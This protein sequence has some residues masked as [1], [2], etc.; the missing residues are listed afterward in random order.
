MVSRQ[1]GR[2]LNCRNTFWH[3]LYLLS[4]VLSGVNSNNQ[5]S[6]AYI[7]EECHTHT[8][9]GDLTKLCSDR[10]GL[11]RKNNTLEMIITLINN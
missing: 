7:S 11:Q 4:I 3:N 10:G 2:P 1:S 9:Y 8:N 5:T 6:K